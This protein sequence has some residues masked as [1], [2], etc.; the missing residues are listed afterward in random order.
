MNCIF[1]K[2]LKRAGL[3][4]EKSIVMPNE[5]SKED[6]LMVHHRKYLR[7]LKVRFKLALRQKC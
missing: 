5:A 6:L 2:Y 7:S 4:S 3:L 1:F